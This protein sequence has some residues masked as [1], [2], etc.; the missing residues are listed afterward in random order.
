M[1]S[2]VYYQYGNAVVD[3]LKRQ[4]FFDTWTTLISISTLPHEIGWLLKKI[5]NCMQ[6]TSIFDTL[7]V[8]AN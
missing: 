1:A 6:N 5:L 2:Y 7:N 8:N 4:K 3:F